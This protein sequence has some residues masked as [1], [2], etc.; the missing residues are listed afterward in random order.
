[1]KEP[2]RYYAIKMLTKELAYVP[3]KADSPYGSYEVVLA[4]DY[5]ALADENERLREQADGIACELR[6]ITE[7][8]DDPRINNT[9]SVVEWINEVQGKQGK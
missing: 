1:M 5:D 2:P 6:E 9:M 8:I 3:P 4:A 7:A